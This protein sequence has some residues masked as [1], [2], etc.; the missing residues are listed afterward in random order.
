MADRTKSDIYREFLPLV[1][2]GR[3]EL[4]DDPRLIK[5]L[6]ALERRVSRAG[7]DTIDHAFG[8]QDDLANAVAGALVAATTPPSLW[9][10]APPPPS[11]EQPCASCGLS[12]AEG[13]CPHRAPTF[14]ELQRA[15]L[16][17]GSWRW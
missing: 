12:H 17:Y 7:R 8:E 5:Q 16:T 2:S 11:P 10:L 1:T 3:L 13:R 15:G 14:A 9:V 6:L 4:L